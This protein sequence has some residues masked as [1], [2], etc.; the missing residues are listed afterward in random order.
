MEGRK[1]PGVE[2]LE[3]SGFLSTLGARRQ[4]AAMP[5]N[6]FHI[7]SIENCFL[8]SQGHPLKSRTAKRPFRGI[9]ALCRRAPSVG[10]FHAEAS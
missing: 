8:G 5:R 3:A 6:T 1:R 4:S 9:A 7:Y 2:C 10:N